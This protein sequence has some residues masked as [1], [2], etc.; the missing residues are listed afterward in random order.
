M[1]MLNK[2]FVRNLAGNIVED[3]LLK[4]FGNS[5]EFIKSA[6]QTL[7]GKTGGYSS[8]IS[9]SLDEAHRVADCGY[10]YGSSWGDEVSIKNKICKI[11]LNLFFSQNL[12]V[13]HIYC[14]RTYICD[15]R[16]GACMAPQQ[17]IT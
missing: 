13:H 5:K 8:N 9:R 10:E 3:E 7:K 2:C 1:T 17:K 11:L 4:K 6:A 14:G 12:Y 15:F 16:W